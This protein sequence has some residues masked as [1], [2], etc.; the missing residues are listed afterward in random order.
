MV[1][2]LATMKGPVKLS[3]NFSS[4]EG[5]GPWSGGNWC[6]SS[7]SK[8]DNNGMGGPGT[9]LTIGGTVFG[10]C[11]VGQ[12]V[13]DNSGSV[14]AG[15]IITSLGTGTGGA[16]TYNV[17][18]TQHVG[19]EVLSTF[20]NPCSESGIQIAD[21][22]QCPLQRQSQVTSTAPSPP[23]YTAT[24]Y[25]SQIVNPYPNGTISLSIYRNCCSGNT[26]A[27]TTDSATNL[28]SALTVPGTTNVPYVGQSWT[29][30]V[31]NT[32]NGTVTIGGGSGVTLPGAPVSISQGAS[33]TFICTV[34]GTGVSA[35]VIC[36]PQ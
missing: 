30:L 7:S 18:N 4:G 14:A 23:P 31:N 3:N 1:E 27:L 35:G 17:N 20:G 9:T 29:L 19:L 22:G 13:V 15:T 21:Q 25:A 24:L 26:L 8:I 34:T 11:A 10:T 36:N 6:Y 12:T 32:R 28:V 2:A 33:K 16:G 5:V